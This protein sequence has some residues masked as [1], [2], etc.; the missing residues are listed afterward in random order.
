MPPSWFSWP[1]AQLSGVPPSRWL[2]APAGNVFYVV[3]HPL[4]RERPG[5]LI[6]VRRL[7][8]APNGAIAWRVLYHSRDAN[9]DDI[10]V[11]GVVVAPRAPG[12]RGGRPVVGWGHPTT[13]TVAR[14]AAL[15]EVSIPS[16]SS[17]DFVPYSP[18]A[19]SWR[20]PT[21]RAWG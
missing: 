19:M 5:S 12:P 7:Y 2:S 1:G 10:A 21:I 3:P 6:R 17:R 9:G 13:G 16:F 4:P 15:R 8:G 14:A 20:R 11:S 18:M